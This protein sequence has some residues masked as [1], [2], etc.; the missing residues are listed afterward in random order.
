MDQTNPWKTISTRFVYE[1]PWISLRED[2]VIQ[3]DGKPSIYGVMHFKNQAIGI[4]PIDEKGNIHLVGQFRY[5][6]NLFSWEIPEGGC[7]DSEDP[8]AA[9]K[10]ELQE[11][12]GLTAATWKE[13]GRAYLSNSVSDEHAIYYLATDLKEGKAEPE[14][15]ERLS[16]KCIPFAEALAM[17][18]RGE[19]TDSI[20][21]IAILR[22]ALYLKEQQQ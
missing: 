7:L 14:G 22:Y 20:S 21:V 6:L 11:E 15:S 19:I 5:A 9:G 3:P 10:R 16:H 17:V 8:L 1:N 4:L 2:Q 13:L 18:M 12:T